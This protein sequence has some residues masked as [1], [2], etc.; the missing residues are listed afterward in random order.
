MVSTPSE[1]REEVAATRRPSECGYYWWSRLAR[2][3]SPSRATRRL[4]T[5]SRAGSSGSGLAGAVRRTFGRQSTKCKSPRNDDWWNPDMIAQSS[6]SSS[7]TNRRVRRFHHGRL[8]RQSE[9][10]DPGEG[11]EELAAT[12]TAFA[13]G[14]ATLPRTRERSFSTST[15]RLRLLVDLCPKLDANMRMAPRK[16]DPPAAS[17][18]SRSSRSTSRTRPHGTS[19]VARPPRNPAARS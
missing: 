1:H 4:D 12:S 10:W 15:C 11:R 13:G 7:T 14:S 5:L 19:R 8:S 3:T 2:S 16:K 6:P 9:P 17:A 18:P